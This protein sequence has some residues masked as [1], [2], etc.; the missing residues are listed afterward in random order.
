MLVKKIKAGDE[1]AFSILFHK[2]KPLTFSFCLS[3][4]KDVQTAE[5]LVTDV[6][7]T[8]YRKISQL[9]AD[10]K[11]P[12]W[13]RR[14][15]RNLSLRAL[16][17]QSSQLIPLKECSQ[18][19]AVEGSPLD[20]LV[21][22]ELTSAVIQAIEALP[23]AEKQVIRAF[24]DGLSHKEIGEQLDIAPQTSMN[25]L[26]RIRKRLLTGLKR[27]LHSIAALLQILTARRIIMKLMKLSR[28]V[29]IGGLIAT[30]LIIS[31][32]L[33]AV[34]NFRHTS[35]PTLNETSSALASANAI[36][37]HSVDSHTVVG[38]IAPDFRLKTLDGRKMSLSDFRGRPVIVN[39]WA[40]GAVHARKRCHRLMSWQSGILTV[41]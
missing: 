7:Y 3:I 41:V 22:L 26:S 14:I 15:A 12:A 16:K 29:K 33:W 35:N 38:K 18:L 13:L 27:R 25:Q 8:A 20:Q 9:K 17:A 1:R 23:D 28:Q 2:Y 34:A 5:E 30:A 10:E 24:V 40:T 32:S 39:F 36:G 6:L 31:A 21:T 4:T 37:L 11:F 19:H